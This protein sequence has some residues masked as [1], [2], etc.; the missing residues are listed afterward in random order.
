MTHRQTTNCEHTTEERAFSGTWTL[1]EIRY[2]V[3]ELGYRLLHVYEMWE[4][5]GQSTTLFKDFIV[6][7]MVTK[8][9]SKASGLVQNGMLTSKGDQVCEYLKSMTGREFTAKDFENNPARRTVAKL[10]QNAFTGKWGEKE[11]HSSTATFYL[12]DYRKAWQLLYDSNLQILA[13]DVLTERGDMLNVNYVQR[14]GA[15]TGHLKKNDHIVAHITAYGRLMLSRLEQHLG[16]A[17]IYEDTDSAF[18]VKLDQKPYQVGFRTG[19]LELELSDGSMW[20]CICRKSY[21]YLKGQD[22]KPVCKQK[23]VP[24]K[25]SSIQQFDSTALRELIVDEKKESIEVDQVLFTTEFDDE[26][27]P[28]KRT[29]RRKKNIKFFREKA[30]RQI[31]W[32][33]DLASAKIID[34][35][36]YGWR[37][38]SN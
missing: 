1:T 15:T 13:I 32:P 18:H 16:D 22:Q 5:E 29:V 12:P 4:Y 20:R 31:L 28:F 14:A 3:L 24:L 10:I 21:A 2:A 37:F 30:K 25:L 38:L 34:S 9:C 7:F 11:D 33:E 8:I 6:P 27:V 19:D 26:H 23:G 17:L 35:L 36:P